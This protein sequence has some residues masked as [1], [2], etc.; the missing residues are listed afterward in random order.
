MKTVVTILFSLALLVAQ[1]LS[2]AG[3]AVSDRVDSGLNQ[4]CGCAAKC[5]VARSDVPK[6]VSP[7]APAANATQ[8]VLQG[9]A[10]ILTVSLALPP[11]YPA[12]SFSSVSPFSAGGSIPLYQRNCSYLI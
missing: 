3:T 5:C 9:L 12:N 8:E 4:C 11:V 6:P 2:S 1:T 10:D 7:L